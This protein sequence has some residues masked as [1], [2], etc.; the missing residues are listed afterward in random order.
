MEKDGQIS[1]II[2]EMKLVECADVRDKGI[3]EEDHI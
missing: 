3:E 2:K 1:K